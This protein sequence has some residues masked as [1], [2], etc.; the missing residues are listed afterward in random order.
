MR[1]FSVSGSAEFGMVA[2]SGSAEF[3]MVARSL[4]FQVYHL[5]SSLILEM[6]SVP[7]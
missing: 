5:I 1:H 6:L 7:C 4:P 2:R 3:G